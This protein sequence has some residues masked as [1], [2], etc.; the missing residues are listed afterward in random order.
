MR[1]NLAVGMHRM[2]VVVVDT[3]AVVVDMLVVADDNPRRRAWV[4][5]IVVAVVRLCPHSLHKS[6]AEDS[7]RIHRSPAMDAGDLD[8]HPRTLLV[9]HR[10]AS[11]EQTEADRPRVRSSQSSLLQ[12]R[13]QPEI[14]RSSLSTRSDQFEFCRE[15][16]WVGEGGRDTHRREAMGLR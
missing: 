6:E 14:L 3:L 13:Q 11:V 8:I 9:H 10:L 7:L 15:K 2:L 5:R 12:R 16:V 4:V 1:S